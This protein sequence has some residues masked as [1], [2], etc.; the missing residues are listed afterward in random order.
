MDSTTHKGAAMLRADDLPAISRVGGVSTTRLVSS[1]CGAQALLNGFTSSP[2]GAAVPVH[3]HNVEESV[4]VVDGE[5]VIEVEG[6]PPVQA[7]A[8]DVT[9]IPPSLPHRFR[10]PSAETTLKI[11]WTYAAADAT[12]TVV[13][14]G[15]T[16]TIDAEHGGA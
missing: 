14:T 2:P 13:E 11:F 3:F 16:Q 8:G 15:E 1:A 10:N 12:R 7:R 9:W 5:A 6:Q 4:L